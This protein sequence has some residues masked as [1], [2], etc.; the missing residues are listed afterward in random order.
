MFAALRPSLAGR[1]TTE[2]KEKAEETCG[3]KHREQG[4]QL[5]TREKRSVAYTAALLELPRENSDDLEATSTTS[6]CDSKSD[7]ASHDGGTNTQPLHLKFESQR[8]KL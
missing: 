2:R 5:S 7:P 6:F 4:E 8:P 3:E 1:V